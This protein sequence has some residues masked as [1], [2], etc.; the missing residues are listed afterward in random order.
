MNAARWWMACGFAFSLGVAWTPSGAA[1]PAA[2]V[3]FR[4]QVLDQS[5][6]PVKAALVRAHVAETTLTTT[7]I[8]APTSTTHT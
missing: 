3:N 4:G 2:S 7:A 1:T 8:T 5:G 6:R